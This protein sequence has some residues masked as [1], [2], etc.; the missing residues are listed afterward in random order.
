M[1][2]Y[3]LLWLLCYL[4]SALVALVALVAVL[5][6]AVGRICCVLALAPTL[7]A[8]R[9]CYPWRAYRGPS[10]PPWVPSGDRPTGGGDFSKRGER[11]T[12]TRPVP[13]FMREV[14]KNVVFQRKTGEKRGEFEEKESKGK[15]KEEKEKGCCG[16]IFGS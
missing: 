10:R 11:Q 7:V 12:E 13:I 4:L 3:C 9:D 16:V 14:E 5:W 8:C 15:G 1:A 2:S 6:P